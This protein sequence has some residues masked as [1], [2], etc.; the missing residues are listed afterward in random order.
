MK[1][2]LI[3]LGLA[4]MLAFGMA[5]CGGDDG[6][7]GP[8]GPA[9]PS[10]P[11]GPAGPSGAATIKVSELTAEQWAGYGLRVSQQNLSN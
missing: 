7:A 4:A 3:A 2:P 9:G 1:R 11:S 8:A 6:A 5:G 10:G